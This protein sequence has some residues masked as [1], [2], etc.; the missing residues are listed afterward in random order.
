MGAKTRFHVVQCGQEWGGLFI[1]TND[2][3]MN[4]RGVGSFLFGPTLKVCGIKEIEQ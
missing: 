4:Q 2:L 1:M 3:M